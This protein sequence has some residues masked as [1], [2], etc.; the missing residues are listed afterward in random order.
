[1]ADTVTPQRR[2]E[3]MAAI[4]SRDT[5]PEL[6][7]RRF[8]HAAGLRFRVHRKDLPGRPDLVFPSRRLCL[9]VHGCFWHGCPRCVDGTREVKSNQAFWQGKVAGNKA[10]DVRNQAKLEALGWSVMTLWEC[11]LKEPGRLDALAGEIVTIPVT[12]PLRPSAKRPAPSAR[13]PGGASRKQTR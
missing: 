11:E 2:S 5:T 13:S 4:R 1:M 3:I 12:R 8:L 9:L 6:A 10:R 7:V